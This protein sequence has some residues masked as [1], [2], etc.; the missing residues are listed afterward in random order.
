MRRRQTGQ[1][2]TRGDLS[3]FNPYARRAGNVSAR[4]RPS[5]PGTAGLANLLPSAGGDDGSGVAGARHLGALGGALGTPTSYVDDEDREDLIGGDNCRETRRKSS[6]ES[7]GLGG[8]IYSPAQQ[9]YHAGGGRGNGGGGAMGVCRRALPLLA[10]AMSVLSLCALLLWAV[11][12]GLREHPHKGAAAAVG[13]A[14]AG[15]ESPGI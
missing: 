8:G 12:V 13:V 7:S 2:T 5:T 11:L 4:M 6:F 3:G 9:R 10:K 1:P 15:E 14:A